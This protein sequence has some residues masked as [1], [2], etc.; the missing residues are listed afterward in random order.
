MYTIVGFFCIKKISR[1]FL[2]QVH[3]NLSANKL[4]KTGINPVVLF[5]RMTV[6]RV[7]KIQLK[8]SLNWL[9]NISQFYLT[10]IFVKQTRHLKSWVFFITFNNIQIYLIQINYSIPLFRAFN[11]LPT[12]LN[13][14]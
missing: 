11:K 9:H 10:S 14:L 8:N 13:F 12:Y 4:C 5:I 7:L 2:F 1:K 6:L 3:Q